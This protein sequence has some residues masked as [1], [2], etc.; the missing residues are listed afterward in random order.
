MISEDGHLVAFTSVATNLVQGDT[1][2]TWDV[3]LRNLASG[4]TERVSVATGGAQG[5]GYSSLPTM[6]DDGRYVAFQSTSQ[7]FVPGG[8]LGINIF[9]RDRILATTEL[10]SVSTAGAQPH[11]GGLC[12]A[13]SI[14]GDGRYVVFDSQNRDLVSGDSNAQADVFLHDRESVGFVNLCNPGIGGTIGCPC[15][16]PPN[17]QDQGCD[18][19]SATGGASLSASGIAYL[20]IDSLAFTTSGETPSA[21]SMVMQGNSVIPNGV[22]YGQGVR[23]LG[24]P[25]IRRLFV[26][27]A[28]AGSISAPDLGAGDP[29]VSARSAAKGDV[30]QPGQSRWYLVYYR[31]PTVLG[32]CPATSTF[33]TTQTGRVDWSL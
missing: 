5:T 8:I 31:D 19:S 17:G 20:S 23:C 27:Q 16:N 4:V 29:T 22:V 32:G 11:H 15:G 10:V 24:G 1:N 9:V 6:S 2:G 7:E 30:I 26:K 12:V 25:L 13:P 14:S 28:V 3:F 21:L 18:N 33:N